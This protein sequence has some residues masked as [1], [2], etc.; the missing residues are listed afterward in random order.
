[1]VKEL[2]LAI[3]VAVALSEPAGAAPLPVLEL[4][5]SLVDVARFVAPAVAVVMAADSNEGD[6]ESVWACAN[7]T[8][9]TSQP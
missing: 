3:V 5:L 4:E 9:G 7:A 8:R 1:M 2:P 6:A